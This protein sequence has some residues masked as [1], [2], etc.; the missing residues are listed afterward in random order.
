MPFAPFRYG[1]ACVW[2]ILIFGIYDIGDADDVGTYKF[3]I[4]S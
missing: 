2:L 3:D 4:T 1:F